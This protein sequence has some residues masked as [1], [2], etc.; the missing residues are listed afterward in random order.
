MQQLGVSRQDG[1]TFSFIPK[2]HPSQS[3]AGSPR[4]TLGT[5]DDNLVEQPLILS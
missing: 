3:A 4:A 1:P 2:C 5:E